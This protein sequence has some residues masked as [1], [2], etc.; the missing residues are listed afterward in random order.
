MTYVAERNLERDASGEPIVH[1]LVS[2]F[3]SDFVD[4]RYVRGGGRVN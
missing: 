1:P 4:G 2:R 3:F